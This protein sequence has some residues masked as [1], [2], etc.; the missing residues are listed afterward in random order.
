MANTPTPS[1]VNL[2]E[3]EEALKPSTERAAPA[4][5]LNMPEVARATTAPQAEPTSYSRLAAMLPAGVNE[6]IVRT[7]G[8]PVDLA[9]MAVNAAL[10]GEEPIP[11]PAGV[12]SR[13]ARN[14]TFGRQEPPAEGAQP[15]QIREP[16][17]GSEWM[18]RQMGRVGADPTRFEPATLPEMALKGAGLGVGSALSGEAAGLGLLRSG[19]ATMAPRAAELVE[20]GLGAFRSPAVTATNVGVS[21]PAG[22]AGE[23]VE[24]SLERTGAEG[25][26][27][28]PAARLATELGTGLGVAG[29]LKAIP[30]VAR[31][32]R[33]Y[34]APMF[35]SMRETAVG[36]AL[37]E[38][39]SKPGEFRASLQAPAREFVP[40]SEPTTFQATGDLG[41]GALERSVD[42]ALMARGDTAFNER[43]MTQNAR[44]LEQLNQI[45]ADGDPAVL[46]RFLRSEF[47]DLD[48]AQM[49]AVE[50]AVREANVF[51]SQLGGALNPE[52]YGR[53][54]RSVIENKAK[55]AREVRSRLYDAI[56]PD[57]QINIVADPVRSRVE[58]VY[59]GRSDFAQPISQA[60]ERL[61]DITQQL[62]SVMRF[63]DLRALDEWVTS[64][65]SDEMRASGR[66]PVWGRL[67]QVKS[68][69]SDA[70]DNAVENQI[71]Y[72]QRRRAAGTLPPE[73][74]ME[75]RLRQQWQ[76]EPRRLEPSF[77]P[78][79]AEALEAAKDAHRAYAR[80]YGAEPIGGV[81]ETTGFKGDYSMPNAAVAQR[82][83][84]PGPRGYEQAN[85]FRQAVDNDPIAIAAMQD[86]AVMSMLRAAKNPD[87][88]IDPAKF[89]TWAR[90][91]QDALR[92]F[93]E[94]Q[95]RFYNA[96]TASEAAA[97]AAARRKAV[98]DDTEKSAVGRILNITDTA[99]LANTIGSM[100]NRSDSVSQLRDLAAKAG[101]DPAAQQGL[102]TSVAD[103]ITN[104][105]VVPAFDETTANASRI[106][107]A[108]FSRFLASNLDALAQVFTRKE[109]DSMRAIAADIQRS[110]MSLR[111]TALPG[112]STTAQDIM[113]NARAEAMRE[114]S[115]LWFLRTVYA[116]MAAGAGAGTSTAFTLGSMA[117]APL[118]AAMGVI[119]GAAYH[120]IAS[121]REAGIA[122]MADLM[123]QALLHPEV[124]RAL[125]ARV[126]NRPNV[127]SERALTTALNQLSLYAVPTYVRERESE[128]VEGRVGRAHGGRIGRMSEHRSKAD[129]LIRDAE[130]AK[131]EL[132]Q[133]TKPI[134][135]MSDETVAK[136]LS[137]ADQAI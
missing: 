36:R 12:A 119:A 94:L 38:A 97:E 66:S 20:T 72:E 18:F 125:V 64:A 39:S 25:P 84:T 19:L 82:M 17:M 75:A 51:A 50:E 13:I 43:R 59:Q 136:A 91:H 79:A 108:Q 53:L 54:V 137:I 16:I 83:F 2:G 55:D 23:T 33:D 96:V 77:T 115:N 24:R 78:E 62:P 6:A 109:I 37:L 104:R 32:V 11:T 86:Y 92:A 46:T 48:Q 7:L 61:Y 9:T 99:D 105:Y 71:A 34:V 41:I 22:A 123:K 76:L 124:A 4:R 40:G 107:G 21:A 117:D 88:T 101:R 26:T 29:A 68:A 31:G 118:F 67:S 127:G 134:L 10:R 1:G 81:L 106:K 121:M 135:E 15:Y 5:P 49:N 27:Y 45:A 70:I 93:P 44:R 100:F 114:R 57:N 87:G 56:D 133:T 73:Q 58:S 30:A 116:R 102:R 122:N 60:E 8:M 110:D 90:T 47:A 132:G 98:I 80:L 95:P 126:P 113:A 42:T 89:D 69:L 128:P 28:A 103:F 3:L 85:A 130:R 35:Q 65:M 120:P 112:R 131:K 111:A 14:L 52:D 129:S 74:S 63:N